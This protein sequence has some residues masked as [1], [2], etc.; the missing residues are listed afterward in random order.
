VAFCCE[1]SRQEPAHRTCVEAA[2]RCLLAT[3]LHAQEDWAM[4]AYNMHKVAC[5]PS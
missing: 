3:A 2:A 4:A 1:G 5:P